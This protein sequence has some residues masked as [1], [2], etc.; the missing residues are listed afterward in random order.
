MTTTG[1]TERGR[2]RLRN[3]DDLPAARSGYIDRGPRNEAHVPRRLLA[4]RKTLAHAIR[5][6]GHTRRALTFSRAVTMHSA[7]RRRVI[8]RAV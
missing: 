7:P 2:L 6:D 5:V 4:E 3:L 8:L 1:G